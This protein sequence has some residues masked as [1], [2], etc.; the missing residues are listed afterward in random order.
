MHPQEILMDYVLVHMNM[1]G[2]LTST[3]ILLLESGLVVA[4]LRLYADLSI[5]LFALLRIFCHHVSFYL[6]PL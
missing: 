4:L 6:S 1:I 5:P 3:T 2:C